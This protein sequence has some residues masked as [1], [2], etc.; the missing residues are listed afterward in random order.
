MNEK[1][2]GNE[3]VNISA[4]GE[5]TTP[6]KAN[7]VSWARTEREADGKRGFPAHIDVDVFMRW[8]EGMPDGLKGE[9]TIVVKV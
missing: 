2:I 4:F 8:P 1:F 9:V 5:E 7:K 6:K 3:T